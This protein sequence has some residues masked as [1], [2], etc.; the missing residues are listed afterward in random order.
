MNF[1]EKPICYICGKELGGDCWCFM[2]LNASQLD[3]WDILISKKR[4]LCREHFLENIGNA[5][6]ARLV[7]EHL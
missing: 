7:A 6:T 5:L 4:Y 2:R 1:L 3:E